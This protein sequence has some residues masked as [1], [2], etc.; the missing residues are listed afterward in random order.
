[1]IIDS[2]NLNH[3]RVFESV[4]R[5]ESMTKAAHELCLTQSGVSQHIKQ[6]EDNLGL[7]LFTRIRHKPIPTFEAKKIYTK[8]SK[9][10]FSIEEALHEIK[11]EERILSGV[12]SIGMPIEFG[13][14]I[15]LP[16]LAQLRK[17][18]P[19]ISFKIKY[20]FVSDMFTMLLNG[21]LDFAFVDSY[22]VDKHIKTKEVYNESLVLCASNNYVKSFGNINPT[23]EYFQ[24]LSYIALLEDGIIIQEWFKN[25]YPKFKK[26]KLNICASMV[27]VQGVARMIIED[28]GVGILPR[29]RIKKLQNEGHELHL[30]QDVNDPLLNPISLAHLE[31]V[32]KI[33]LMDEAISFIEESMKSMNMSD[34]E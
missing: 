3:L 2:I 28:L 15:V 7:K 8:C 18:N 4:Y 16:I 1:M 30:F 24:E 6:L 14:N 9:G 33:P 25:N 29:H 13:N 32:R 22:G 19:N 20:G 27:N 23:N 34:S 17:N 5:N 10:L 11:G 12:L 31:G 26:F 21:K